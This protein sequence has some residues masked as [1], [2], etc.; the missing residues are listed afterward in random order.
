MDNDRMTGKGRAVLQ[1]D[2]CSFQEPPSAVLR[3]KGQRIGDLRISNYAKL[4]TPF[5]TR[6]SAL[7]RP[8]L[9]ALS[10]T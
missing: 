4:A 10:S 9:L 1:R 8:I 6:F 2:P 3:D 5:E 7:I